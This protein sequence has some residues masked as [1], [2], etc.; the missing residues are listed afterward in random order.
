VL[1]GGS[2]MDSMSDQPGQDALQLIREVTLDD[3]EVLRDYATRLFAE[4]LPGVW[5]RPVPTIAEELEFI[6]GY[7]ASNSTLIVAEHAEAVVGL[8]GLLG[9]TLE[10]QSHVASLAVSVDREWRGRG[11]GTR[12][13]EHLIAWAPKHGVTRLEVE[14]LEINPRAIALYERLG[15]EHEGI[16][17]SA[18]AIDG[19]YVDMICLAR[20]SST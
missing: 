6:A 3:A 5:R 1:D 4:D 9:G 11:I 8:A 14:A 2:A 18:A 16:R 19:R 20:L 12:L 17:R 15:F 7:T 13:I 10:Q